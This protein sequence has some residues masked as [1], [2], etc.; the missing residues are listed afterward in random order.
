MVVA[1]A[2]HT[3]TRLQPD[4][5]VTDRCVAV[6]SSCAPALAYPSHPDAQI[7]TEKLDMFTHLHRQLHIFRDHLAMEEKASKRVDPKR[8]IQY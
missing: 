3:T 2:E 8:V 1:L 7:L 6:L 4:I 5:A